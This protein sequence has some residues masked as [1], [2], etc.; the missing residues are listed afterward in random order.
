MVGRRH[1]SDRYSILLRSLAALTLPTILLC[2]AAPR[3]AGAELIFTDPAKPSLTF[4]NMDPTRT[5][6]CFDVELVT[7]V[8]PGIGDDSDGGPPFSIAFGKGNHPGGGFNEI[9]Y[10]G[11]GIAPGGTYT[12]SFPGWPEGTVF[13]VTFT[14]PPPP[15][16][17]V[18]R[19]SNPGNYP[20]EGFTTAVPEPSGAAFLAAGVFIAIGCA[21]RR[22]PTARQRG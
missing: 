8:G 6:T 18:I 15:I 7:P 5:A 3:Q 9:V 19:I 1:S 10:Q 11:T 17:G 13:D 2:I 14:Y 16:P 4:T 12:H 21:L 22:K 20:T